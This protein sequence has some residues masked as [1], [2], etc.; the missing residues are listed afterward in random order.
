MK[1]RDKEV[2]GSPKKSLEISQE[3]SPGAGEGG[4]GEACPWGIGRRMRESHTHARTHT[5]HKHIQATR[6]IPS[7]AEQCILIFFGVNDDS[8]IVLREKPAKG[9]GACKGSH[10]PRCV[11]LEARVARRTSDQALLTLA[12]GFSPSRLVVER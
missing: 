9:G 2:K 12:T 6:S 3:A 1:G 7:N 11:T 10:G 8:R 4:G 5:Q